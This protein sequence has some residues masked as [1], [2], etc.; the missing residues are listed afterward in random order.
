MPNIDPAPFIVGYDATEEASDGLA[1]ATTL[2]EL[3]GRRLL[4]ARVLPDVSQHPG[5]G[6]AEQ[7]RVR[8]AVSET[9]AAILAVVPDGSLEVVPMMDPS[10]AAGLHAL[11]ESEHAGMLVLGS[12]HHSRAG[13]LL[14]GGTADTVL[15]GAPCPVAVAPPGQR[16]QGGIAPEAVGVAWDGSPSSRTALAEAVSL[17]R[18]LGWPLNVLHVEPSPTARPI[19]GVAGDLA[20]GLATAKELAGPD[21]RVNA[22]QL[23][24]SPAGELAEADGIGLLVIGSRGRG[25]LARVLLGSVSHAVV[26]HA[27]MPVVVVP[28]PAQP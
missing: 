28:G 24:G 17:A 5:V 22:V 4:V 10:V 19:G 7:M 13:R 23:H 26:H 16:D 15:D 18:A 11:A 25:A 21:V 9:H 14:L 8:H 2:A 12:S 27:R 3:M 1:L 20:D 6:R